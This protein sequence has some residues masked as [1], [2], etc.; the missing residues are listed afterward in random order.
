ME[1]TFKLTPTQKKFITSRFAN[2][3]ELLSRVRKF[4]E[5][6]NTVG[7]SITT[8]RTK[9][10][11]VSPEYRCDCVWFDAFSNTVVVIFKNSRGKD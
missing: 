6:S 9:G 3:D 8:H 1:K 2:G 11:A 4:D 7:L 5:I 10:I